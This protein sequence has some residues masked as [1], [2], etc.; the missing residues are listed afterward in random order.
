[1]DN[2][3]GIQITTLNEENL[4]EV[5][6]SLETIERNTIEFKNLHPNL[7]SVVPR[8]GDFKKTLNREKTGEETC[9]IA[10]L[11]SRS[12]GC[13]HLR[14]WGD[15]DIE[16]IVA[17]KPTASKYLKVPAIYNFWVKSSYR[18]KGV[19][20][21]L[22]NEAEF[23]ALKRNYNQ[24]GIT[25]DLIN[26]RAR[27]LY[28]RLGYIDVGLGIIKT[29]GTYIQNGISIEW[30]NGPEIYLCKKLK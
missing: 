11:D 26:P 20:Q 16:R 12:V 1:M 15:H 3:K 23:F 24:L 18:S 4:R 25:V 2:S 8:K 30:Q 22:I 28:E 6:Q 9:L 17:E 13:L 7:H 29:S 21:K 14:W 5:E 10:W 27:K 19:G